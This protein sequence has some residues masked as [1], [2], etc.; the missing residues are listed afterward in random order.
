MNLEELEAEVL[1][2]NPQARAQLAAKL[3]QSLDVLS[4]GEHER[5]WADE[6]L[7]RR[8]AEA[9]PGAADGVGERE[10][11]D[12]PLCG[13]PVERVLEASSTPDRSGCERDE[14]V[15]AAV[16]AGHSGERAADVVADAGPRMRQRTDVV[17]DPHGSEAPLAVPIV[18]TC[19]LCPRV[20]LQ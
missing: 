13:D 15:L 9:P 10:R 20:R 11:D 6:A 19:G 5:L 7:R 17:D 1:Q 14:L 8:P 18:R 12:A 16:R 2:L 4:E 3:L